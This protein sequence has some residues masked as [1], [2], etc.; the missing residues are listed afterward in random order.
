MHRSASFLAFFL[1]GAYVATSMTIP[2]TVLTG[3]LGSGKTTLLNRLLR[4]ERLADAL[5]LVNEVGAVPLD[6]LLVSEV[7]E[8]VVVLASGC[9]CCSVR[10]DLVRTLC[11]AYVQATRG[12]MKRF[13]RVFLETT[14][15]ADPTAVVQTLVKNGLVA[16]GFHLDQIVTTFDAVLGVQTLLRHEEAQRQLALADRVVITKCDELQPLG[17]DTNSDDLTRIEELLAVRSPLATVQRAFRGETDLTPIIA[18]RARGELPEARP[19]RGLAMA[20]DP[21][22]KPIEDAVHGDVRTAS[23]ILEQPVPFAILSAW[24]AMISQ[25]H[26]DKILRLKGIVATT[27]DPSQSGPADGCEQPVVLQAVQH[28][29]YPPE[30]LRAWPSEDHRSRIV[31]I[32]RG[33]EDPL[34]AGLVASLEALGRS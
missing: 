22:V 17:A 12:T 7:R 20:T 25:I 18:G 3:F 16:R 6:H 30:R 34:F 33:M 28:V 14:G 11:D 4:D 23:V 8:D 24:I 21:A 10:N 19:K 5:V 27:D 32:V 31:L 26:G 29:V 2:V 13:S 1:G 15:L 9:V